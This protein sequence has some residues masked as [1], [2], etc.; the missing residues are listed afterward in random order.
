MKWTR[1]FNTYLLRIDIDENI[2]KIFEFFFVETSISSGVVSAIGAVKNT[3]LGYFDGDKK[4]YQKQLFEEEME[5]IS[6]NGNLSKVDGK[7][8]MHAHAV[9]SGSDYIARAGHFFDGTVAVTMEV[10][11]TSNEIDV[12]RTFDETTQLKLLS[13]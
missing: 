1:E 7:T 4:E 13:F 6:F 10:T 5:L 12:K 3:T 2:N 9:L 11:I 8:F